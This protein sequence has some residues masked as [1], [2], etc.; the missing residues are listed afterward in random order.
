MYKLTPKEAR[1]KWTEA[2]R[3]GEYEQGTYG[4]QD[5]S[6]CCC[7]GVACNVMRACEGDIALLRTKDGENIRFGEQLHGAYAPVEVVEWLEL[8]TLH[9]RFLPV[10]CEQHTSLVGMNDN[11][12]SFEYIADFIDSNP[13]GLWK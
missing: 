10:D 5:E 6:G 3:S 12:V 1:Q 13:E 9:G 2:L 4:L 7:L 8:A 11:K